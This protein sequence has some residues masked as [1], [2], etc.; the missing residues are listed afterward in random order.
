M[1]DETKI[2]Q[3]SSK[4]WPIYLV[5]KIKTSHE[6]VTVSKNKIIIMMMMIT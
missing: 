2:L 1:Y 6:E 5:T 3:F 4:K